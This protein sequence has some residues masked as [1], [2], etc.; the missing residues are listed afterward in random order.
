[1]S[2]IK[3]K[4]TDG[5]WH[6]LNNIIP[7]AIDVTQTSGTSSARLKALSDA[8]VNEVQVNGVALT[9]T[10]NAVNVQIS[11][12][13]TALTGTGNEA[14]VVNTDSG[15]GAITLGIQFLDCGTY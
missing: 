15:T 4:G 12:A 9:E 14:I 8:T 10:N 1:M 6:V 5:E 13:T 7:K 11:G 2:I 3:Y